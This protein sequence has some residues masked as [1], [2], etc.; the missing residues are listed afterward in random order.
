[1]E[2]VYIYPMEKSTEM[3]KMLDEEFLEAPG[4]HSE[5]LQGYG[6]GQGRHVPL[7]QSQG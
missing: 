4:A 6:P 1:M 5:R 7:H 3:Q 2:L